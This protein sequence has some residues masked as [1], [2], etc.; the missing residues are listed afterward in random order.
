MRLS[1]GQNWTSLEYR[2]ES[3]GLLLHPK[4]LRHFKIIVFHDESQTPKYSHPELSSAGIFACLNAEKLKSVPF[5][6]S[7]IPAKG[8]LFLRDY[9]VWCIR[10]LG[11]GNNKQFGKQQ[12]DS[13]DREA[14]FKHDKNSK[15][16]EYFCS[17]SSH[18]GLAFYGE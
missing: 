15:P 7:L 16:Q 13:C 5:F 11:F 12:S 8:I 4:I 17:K 9:C 2:Q 6:D 1:G 18:L 14:R 10:I 3:E